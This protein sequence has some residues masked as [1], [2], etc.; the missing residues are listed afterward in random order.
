MGEV[1]CSNGGANIYQEFLS[2]GLW[3]WLG[4]WV[5]SIWLCVMLNAP[6][7]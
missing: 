7:G 1:G 6:G 5:V 3:L 4:I 2:Y